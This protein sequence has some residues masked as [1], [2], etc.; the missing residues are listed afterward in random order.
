MADESL[1]LDGFNLIGLHSSGAVVSTKAAGSDMGNPEA[2]TEEIDSFLTDAALERINSYGDR[3]P[4]FRIKI[5]GL[6]A[7]VTAAEVDLLQVVMRA[8]AA[9]TTRATLVWTPPQ[10]QTPVALDL[11]T[12]VMERDYAD[13]WDFDETPGEISR[14]FSMTFKG[15][16]F[17]RSLTTTTVSIPAP[18]PT[19][20]DVTTMAIVGSTANWSTEV[21]LSAAAGA[22]KV[23]NP[24]FE[25]N[26]TGWT[27]NYGTVNRDTA[28]PIT[29]TASAY[30]AHDSE[31]QTTF[32]LAAGQAGRQLRIKTTYKAKI[33]FPGGYPY[34]GS[35]RVWGQTRIKWF[36][37]GGVLISDTPTM[38]TGATAHGVTKTLDTVV[39]APANAVTG[40]LVCWVGYL[41]WKVNVAGGGTA[42]AN[43]GMIPMAPSDGGFLVD[44]VS[45]TLVAAN[46]T[47]PGPNL[48][49]G[50]AGYYSRSALGNI[51]EPS[52]IKHSRVSLSQAVGTKKY[53]AIGYALTGGGFNSFFV[54]IN[55]IDAGGVMT[56][57]DTIW[58]EIPAGVTT[59]N[60]LTVRRTFFAA[61]GAVCSFTITSV[62]ISTEPSLVA[63]AGLQ[64]LRTLP[65]DSGVRTPG[66]IHLSCASGSLGSVII[67]SRRT[68]NMAS[69]DLR[70]K[71]TSGVSATADAACVS[72]Y[73]STLT[74]LHP[75]AIT[76][77]GITPGTHELV[78]R[79]K[80]PTASLSS[81]PITVTLASKMGGNVISNV[82]TRTIDAVVDGTTNWQMVTLGDW[83]LPSVVM[84]TTGQ[85]AITM[86][87]GLASTQID[88][89]WHFPIDP[90][91][92]EI[93]RVEAG[94]A[95]HLW[96]DQPTP[97]APLPAVWLG[98]NADK[99]NAYG[100]IN[101]ASYAEHQLAPPDVTLYVVTGAPAAVDATYFA[102]WGWNAQ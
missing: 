28:T 24:G 41:E 37:A 71:L 73:R 25:S 31:M 98:T 39:T 43:S 86:Q 5:K 2:I 84:A 16:A 95:T 20:P 45:A 40:A 21:E 42:T 53:M 93:L 10:G 79:I 22:E 94:A 34:P 75:F 68:P 19:P 18:S 26:L 14:Y 9:K 30:V 97:A 51:S 65:I 27:V 7:Q 91:E 32:A 52:E 83:M 38:T 88:E 44:T 74:T 85:V 64:A 17:V 89:A 46:I 8:N 70:A 77:G 60:S 72:G 33:N 100:A 58:V 90:E 102:Q 101:M 56:T 4:T 54:T 69:P 80:P 92:G 66:S 12:V 87:T 81:I 47:S 57:D 76:A 50:I 3:T 96:A 78:A 15:P 99:S 49:G 29:G 13:G 23:T 35:E 61:A 6:P 67:A 62:K 55:G 63:S 59:I 1:T 82:E 48:S 11:F 36:D